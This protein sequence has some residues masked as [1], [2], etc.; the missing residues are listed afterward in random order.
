VKAHSRAQ[1]KIRN[2]GIGA[3]EFKHDMKITDNFGDHNNIQNAS[4]A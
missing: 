4:L 3:E 1:E 2:P